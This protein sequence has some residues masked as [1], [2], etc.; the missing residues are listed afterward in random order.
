MNY[1]VIIEPPAAT[2]IDEACHWIGER[3]PVA[4]ANWFHGVMAA[5]ESL[6]DYPTRCAPAPEA[7]E[8]DTPI[9]HLL[10]GRSKHKYRIIFTVVDNNVHVLHIR[11][12]AR[13]PLSPSP[14][15]NDV[16]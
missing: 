11:H 3:S 1:S 13:E 14:D 12:G 9:R 16:P 15:K 6:A 4:E 7:E 8:F 10:F 2:D 5:I